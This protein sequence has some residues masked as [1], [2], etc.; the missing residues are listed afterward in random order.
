MCGGEQ[1]HRKSVSIREDK[2]NERGAAFGFSRIRKEEGKKKG[3]PDE[4]GTIL[5]RTDREY[6]CCH[7]EKWQQEGRKPCRRVEVESLCMHR[8][9]S[10]GVTP[11]SSDGGPPFVAG[12]TCIMKGGYKR[13]GKRQGA[14]Y[15]TYTTTGKTCLG[16]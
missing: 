9:R 7:R 2:Q 5:Y 10:S 8:I 4:A 15:I 14:F 16:K 12:G 3:C 6:D 1:A 13:R 11:T